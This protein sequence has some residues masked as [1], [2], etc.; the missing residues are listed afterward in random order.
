MRNTN[1]A[2]ATQ[3]SINL[4]DTHVFVIGRR[5]SPTVKE[6]GSSVQR[7]GEEALLCRL[8]RRPQGGHNILP[9]PW[10]QAKDPGLAT[11]GRADEDLHAALNAHTHAPRCDARGPLRPQARR[12]KRKTDVGSVAMVVQ[13]ASKNPQR[14]LGKVTGDV[15]VRAAHER[16]REH[17]D[18]TRAGFRRLLRP[19][20]RTCSVTG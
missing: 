8:R 2:A 16:A 4:T 6:P 20:S 9:L 14:L 1:K 10:G 3:E 13:A 5:R 19:A 15:I 11:Y 7:S 12:W 18:G 17:T